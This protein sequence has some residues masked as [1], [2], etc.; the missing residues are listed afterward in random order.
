MVAGLL[1]TLAIVRGSTILTLG[2]SDVA[3]RSISLKK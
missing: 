3:I 2:I 1:G